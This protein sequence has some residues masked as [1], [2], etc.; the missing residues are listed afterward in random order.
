M[1]KDFH[2]MRLIFFSSFSYFYFIVIVF[3]DG[4]IFFPSFKSVILFSSSTSLSPFCATVMLFLVFCLHGYMLMNK[5]DIVKDLTIEIRYKWRLFAT[6]E[7]N[8]NDKN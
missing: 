5:W 3:S 6:L 7:K 8:T 2:I 1:C 4:F